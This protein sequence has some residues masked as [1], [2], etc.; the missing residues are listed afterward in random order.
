MLPRTGMCVTFDEELK[1]C[2]RACK[3]C[4]L[5]SRRIK[6]SGLHVV[7]KRASAEPI[8][9]PAPVINTVL[10]EMCSFNGEG[11]GTPRELPANSA[12]ML[13]PSCVSSIIAVTLDQD[14][15]TSPNTGRRAPIHEPIVRRPI[16]FPAAAVS[17]SLTN[18]RKY[19]KVGLPARR[20][21]ERWIPDLIEL[22]RP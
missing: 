19:P 15:D 21:P 17:Q 9:P 6:V 2:S 10:P 11:D 20:T 1:D 18:F 3:P 4:S 7:A 14:R 22:N 5:L 16:L 8:E 12:Q 13:S